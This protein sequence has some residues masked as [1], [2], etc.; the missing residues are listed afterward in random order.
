MIGQASPTPRRWLAVLG[1][2]SVLVIVTGCGGQA[3]GSPAATA[4]V[5]ATD[6]TDASVPSLPPAGPSLTLTATPGPTP[7]PTAQ[8]ADGLHFGDILR[9][10]VK[11]L[12]ARVAPK[13]TSALVHGYDLSGPA[14]EDKGSIRLDKGDYVSVELG[15]LPIGDTIWYLV[16]PATATALHT[17]G[18]QWYT[19]PP[20][21]GSPLPAWMAASVGSDVY[22]TLQKRP[23]LSEIE[24][25]S[26]VGVVAAGFGNYT[27]EPQARHD[28]FSFE[29]AAAA[30][31]SGT[32]CSLK[33]S[34]VP[35]DTDT[36]PKVAVQ[37]TTTTVKVGPLTGANLGTDWLPTPEGSWSTFTVKVASTCNWAFRLLRL[38][39]D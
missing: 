27:S 30:P 37:T 3:D 21:E 28:G 11:S 7:G 14:P 22:L 31:V 6:E 13:R 10:Q 26:A 23:I 34:L 8:L 16:W 15:P 24:A 36:D 4:V 35:S 32:S 1:V 25:Y 33:I 19:T 2:L 18:T 20:I 39:H 29:Y 5:S 12:A 38:E 9:V 17:E